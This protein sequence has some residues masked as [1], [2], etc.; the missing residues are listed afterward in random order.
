MRKLSRMISM[1]SLSCCL[2][3]AG[4]SKEGEDAAARRKADLANDRLYAG[5]RLDQ[6]GAID[7]GVQPLTMPESSISELLSR[8]NVLAA[9]LK[10][11]NLL[12]KPFPFYKG[13]NIQELM[14]EGKLEAGFLGDMPAITAAATGDVVIV[15][16]V[17]QGFSSIVAGKPMLVSELKGK[18]I[19]TGIGSAAHFTLLNALA[20]EGLTERD[21]ELVGMEVSDMPQALAQGT[22]DAF[23]AWEPTPAMAFAAYPEFHLVHKGLNFAFL[24][25]RRDF[26]T[27]HPVAAREIAAAVARGSLWMREPGRIEQAAHWIRASAAKFQA[28]PYLLQVEQTIALTRNDLLNIP[29]APQIPERMLRENE[30]LWKKFNYLKKNGKIPQ[31]V[32]WSKVRESFDTELL[33]GVLSNAKPY[34]LREFDYRSDNEQDGVK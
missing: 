8:D 26:V 33:R 16:M 15:A 24:C 23:S 1:L 29:M 14:S 18:R 5:Y 31:N 7:L 22:V 34:A 6:E 3:L 13:K 28:A 11:K 12:L 25:F 27:D 2:A 19:A 30:L 17:K 21:V 20:N 4:C 9:Q 10:T 32:P